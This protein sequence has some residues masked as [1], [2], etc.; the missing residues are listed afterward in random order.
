MRIKTGSNLPKVKLRNETSIL[1]MIYQQGAITRREIAKQL[2]VTLPT[3][4]T[5]VKKFL[6]EGILIETELEEQ[7][8]VLG[9]KANA[10]DI[11]PKS[12]YVLGMEWG[13]FGVLCCLSDLRGNIVQKQ[14]IA[15]NMQEVS[16]EEL[17]LLSESL[18]HELLKISD[19]D[20]ERVIG[21]GWTSPGMVDSEQG[22]LLRSSMT[23][24]FWRQK[25]VKADLEKILN[26][27]V[28]IENHVKVRAIGLDMFVRQER[29]EVY[30]YY[31]VQAGISC[32]V[33]VDG[34][35]FGNA[36]YGTGDIGHTTVDIDGPL[37][38]C[39]KH[40]C[41]Q[42]FC[43]EMFIMNKVKKALND[44]K[45]PG[46]SSLCQN[47][48]DLTMEMLLKLIEDQD[49]QVLKL[50]QP[51]IQYMGISISNIVNLLNSR[52]VVV[53]CALLNDPALQEDLTQIVKDNNY[54]KEELQLEM[55]YIA[56][57]RYTGAL[58][59]CALAVK[60]LFIKRKSEEK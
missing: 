46:L 45:L 49:E 55:D 56:A 34:E 23:G 21:M 12:C 3:V 44:G 50:L 6:E 28:C 41:L 47:P 58:G 11:A 48:N 27:P 33:M 32:C 4:T 52:L 40:G 13:P 60:E 53:D 5:T 31:F 19:I 8:C 25:S 10:V 16:Y 26:I 22:V 38:D 7:D 1:G 36:Y 35:P 15:C 30:L 18:V 17:L 20:P 29:P 37:C 9:R 43:G 57:N 2:D 39:G 54:F 59:A 24:V 14:K 42:T 51:T